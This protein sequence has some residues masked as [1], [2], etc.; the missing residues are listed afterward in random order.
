MALWG[1]GL[2]FQIGLFAT[3]L[4]C[5]EMEWFKINYLKPGAEQ[6]GKMIHLVCTLFLHISPDSQ[7]LRGS[8]CTA[9]KK[10]TRQCIW[11]LGLPCRPITPLPL[12]S[13]EEPPLSLSA[14]LTVTTHF[15]KAIPCQRGQKKA[16]AMHL[17]KVRSL[18]YSPEIKC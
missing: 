8:C 3:K 13:E 14:P 12:R 1:R 15:D 11:H 9:R 17:N 18:E 2:Q 4:M 10:L 6:M 5:R 7:C 16:V